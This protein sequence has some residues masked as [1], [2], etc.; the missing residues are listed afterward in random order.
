[1]GL[2][3]Y[4]TRSLYVGGQFE[5]RGVA[6]TAEIKIGDAQLQIDAKTITTIEQQVAY[7]RKANAVHAWFVD[8]VQDGVDECQ[9]SE[10]DL[11][12]LRK[13]RDDCKR[14]LAGDESVLE[15]RAGFFFG[16]TDRDEGY[17]SDLEYTVEAVDRIEREH[18]Q[19]PEQCYVSY[20][21]WASW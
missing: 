16:S 3:M 4:L 21:Y 20:T 7:W 19:F 17:R 12:V 18:G 5:H 11:D 13:L 9:R 10:V 8:N 6:G 2:D 15:P 1:M 14:A